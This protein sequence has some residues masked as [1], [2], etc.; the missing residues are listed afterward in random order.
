M[1]DIN[2]RRRIFL[3]FLF[4]N[5][6]AVP[7]EINSSKIRLHFTFS[8]NLNKRDKDW[9]IAKSLNSDVF[10]ADRVVDAK[11]PCYRLKSV[12]ESDQNEAR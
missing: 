8:A 2:K 9:K 7:T 1:E 12:I 6:G 10:A 4:L 5:V 11:A 3:Q